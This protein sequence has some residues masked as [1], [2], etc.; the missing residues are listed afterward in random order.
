MCRRT[1]WCMMLAGSW[2]L[3]AALTAP[4]SWAQEGIVLSGAGAVNRSMGGASTAAPIDASGAIYWN[5]ASI[6]GLNR[7]E[8]AFGLELLFPHTT[9]SSRVPAN[10]L[11]PG[12]PPTAVAGSDQSNS[13][14]FPLPT[15]G[16]VYRI[17]ESP[18]TLGLGVLT[19][20]GF[21]V[22]YP[23]STTNPILQAPP[24]TGLGVGPVYSELLVMQVVPTAAFQLSER[25]S[26]GIAPTLTLASLRLDP[27]LVAPPDHPGG[28]DF[29]NYPR[30]AH[31]SIRPGGGV[32]AGVFYARP[33][34]WQLGATIKSPQWMESFNFNSMDAQG[35]PLN[36]PF[37]LNYPMI[38]STGVAYAGFP[39]WLLAADLRYIDYANTEGFRRGGFGPNG[40]VQG[41][42]WRSIFGVAGGVQYECTDTISLRLG[43]S[44]NQSPV[45]DEQNTNS[46]LAT[47]NA[48]APSIIEHTLYAGVSW[49][50]NE[51]VMFSAAYAHGFKNSNSGIYRGPVVIVPGSTVLSEASADTFLIGVN[52]Q[53]GSS[54][55]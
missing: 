12:L 21:G 10:A 22:N 32:Q 5:P 28:T 54:R 9:L 52:V 42:G 24:L 23:G 51:S 13:G 48:A 37:L 41:L 45:P 19:V 34:G 55:N 2:L 16:F 46:P 25:L 26:I 29:V 6:T 18:W 7:S 47:I 1:S 36:V 8:T 30:S 3:M 49:R 44:F 33:D 15:F 50:L 4:L 43:Y 17:E 27:N 14:V 39:R 38:A 40:A 11:G 53:F 35:R 20:G 31:S